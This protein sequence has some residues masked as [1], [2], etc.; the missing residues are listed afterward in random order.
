MTEEQVFEKLN[1]IAIQN[2]FET[3]WD[4]VDTISPMDALSYEWPVMAKWMSD[5]VHDVKVELPN[6][7]LTGFQLWEYANALYKLI[8]DVEH[9]FIER[10]TLKDDTDTIE[11][12]F[13]S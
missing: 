4:L 7:K 5:G 12:F 8:G 2:G 11:V 10:F 1:E 9:R 6:R 3:S 13:G